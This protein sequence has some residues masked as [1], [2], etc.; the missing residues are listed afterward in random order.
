MKT[1][2]DTEVVRILD[3]GSQYR[4]L[5]KVKAGGTIEHEPFPRDIRGLAAAMDL[6]TNCVIG[7]FFPARFIQPGEQ[8]LLTGTRMLENSAD[9][10]I[11]DKHRRKK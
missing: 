10:D 5:I 4:V 3:D 9:L 1:V 7:K 11:N 6:A 2:L 8:P